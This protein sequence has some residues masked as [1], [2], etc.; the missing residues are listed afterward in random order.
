VIYALGT[1]A[2]PIIGQSSPSLGLN[3]WGNIVAD[4]DTQSTNLPGVFAGGDI[5][6]GGATVILAMSA[7]RRAAK[8]IAAW[9]QTGKVKWP[10][11]KEDTEA[12]VPGKPIAAPMAA[13]AEETGRAI[14]PKCRQPVEG[15]DAYICCADAQLQWR[16]DDC[17]KVSEGF[18]FPYGMCPHCGGK[19]RALDRDGVSDVSGLTAIRVAFEIELGG[20]AFYTRASKQTKDPALQELFGKFAEMEHEHMATLSRRYH[21]GI[22]DPSDGFRVD[23]A[24]VQ[25]GVE[26]KIDDPATLFRAAIAFEKRAVEF[27][28]ERAQAAAED[29]VERQL[30][31][32]LGAEEAEHVAILETEFARWASGKQ[33]LL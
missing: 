28:G 12:F 26:G 30:Y 19:L 14:C 11:T 15:D 21:V 25:A 13:T 8:A 32:E 9:L 4:D 6:T 20:Q 18:A 27:F 2:N 29:S 10:V 7:G 1:K 3:K 16:C 24:A 5:V 23:I 33:G 31:R 22:P 17:A